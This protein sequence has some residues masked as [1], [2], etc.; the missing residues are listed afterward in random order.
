MFE[1]YTEPA[2]R[3]IFFARYEASQFGSPYIE[4]E[5]LL[6][7][8]LRQDKTLSARFLRGH[9]PFE[10]IRREIEQHSTIREKTATSVDLPLSNE[11]QRVL[12]YASKEAELSQKHIAPSNLLLGLLREEKCF[13]AQILNKHGLRLSTVQEELTRIPHREERQELPVA[14]SISMFS[15]NLTQLA[16]ESRLDPLIGREPELD[17]VI[18]VLCNRKRNNPLIVGERGVGKTAIVHGLAQRIADGRVPALLSEKRILV[19]A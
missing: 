4:T 3:V 2:R 13:A 12:A 7:G 11:S 5:H 8:L 17:A 10:S 1:R 15:R 6:L 18:E 9:A 19:L 16:M 14:S